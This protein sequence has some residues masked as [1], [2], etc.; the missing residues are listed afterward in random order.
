M[1]NMDYL[2]RSILITETELPRTILASSSINQRAYPLHT[3]HSSE[4][5]RCIQGTT[6]DF[7]LGDF[8][9]VNFVLRKFVAPVEGVSPLFTEL[10]RSSILGT[11]CTRDGS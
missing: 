7:S 11:Y 3:A 8:K 1:G 5:R 10:P 4:A 6:E 9:F 2:E